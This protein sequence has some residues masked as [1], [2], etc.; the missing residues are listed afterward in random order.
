MTFHPREDLPETQRAPRLQDYYQPIAQ[1]TLCEWELDCVDCHTAGEAMG[2]GDL[3]SSQAEVQYVQC[4][5]CHGTLEAP[6]LIY[7][8]AD[9][10]DL[11]LRLAFLNPFVDLQVGDTVLKT[12]RDEPLWNIVQQSDGRFLQIGKATGVSYEVPLVQ[13]S[14]CEQKLEEQESRYCHACHA[15]ERP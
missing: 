6:P 10:E 13:G 1:F 15:Y 11:A 3:Y 7:S 5:S 8:I 4:K 2:D 9:A 12:E 14:E